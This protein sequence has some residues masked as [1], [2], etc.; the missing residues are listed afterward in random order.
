MAFGKQVRSVD[1][2]VLFIDRCL[3]LLKPGGRLLIVVPDGILCNS[4]DRYVREYIMGRK[5]EATSRFVGG[6][7]V[8]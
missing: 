7:A 6:K 3:Q 1:P 4:G 2:A 5:D 8:V